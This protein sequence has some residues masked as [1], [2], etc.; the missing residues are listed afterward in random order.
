VSFFPHIIVA[1]LF[2]YLN[3]GTLP[4]DVGGFWGVII[5]TLSPTLT[6]FFNCLPKDFSP[7]FS[8]PG[9]R[10]AVIFLRGLQGWLYA[11]FLTVFFF[12]VPLCGTEGKSPPSSFSFPPR[13]RTDFFF[14][15]S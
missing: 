10:S 9:R 2:G 3:L 14:R 7:Y 4:L 11:P 12:Y 15:R 13:V 5:A 8:N 1:A 6:L